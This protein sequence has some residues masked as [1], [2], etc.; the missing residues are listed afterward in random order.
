MALTN[1]LYNMIPQIAY[2][3]GFWNFESP[4]LPGL[5][6]SSNAYL[7]TETGGTIDELAG[8]IMTGGS[9]VAS[10]TEYL[11]IAHAS[12]PNLR[13]TSSFSFSVWIK[14]GSIGGDIFKIGGKWGNSGNYGYDIFINTNNK[15][16][17][18]LSSNGT[19]ITSCIGDNTLTLNTVWY[20]VVGLF[21]DT[22][23]TIQLYFNGIADGSSVGFAGTVYNSTSDFCI[24]NTAESS[25]YFDGYMDEVIFWNTALSASEVTNLYAIQTT[26]AYKSNAIFLFNLA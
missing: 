6:L 20:H 26:S 16:Y 4:G 10:E 15:I 5:D 3:Q 17:F 25:N 1:L 2:V 24:G 7:L 8:K 22:A 14:R 23:N 21:D 18:R 11:S 12:C 9:F 19:A 13:F